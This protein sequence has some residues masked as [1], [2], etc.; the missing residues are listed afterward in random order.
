MLPRMPLSHDAIERLV[1]TRFNPTPAQ[2]SVGTRMLDQLVGQ[3]RKLASD[4]V[5]M[6][7]K[8]AKV[9][10]H[11]HDSGVFRARYATWGECVRAELDITPNYAANL[12]RV[13]REFREE[14]AVRL[15]LSKCVLLMKANEEDRPALAA[16]VESGEIRTD[17]KLR[18][19][20][21]RANRKLPRGSNGKNKGQHQTH[22]RVR[23]GASVVTRLKVVAADRGTEVEHLVAEAVREFLARLG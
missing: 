18:R 19:E 5:V 1:P 7:W 8:T 4:S 13:A 15:G 10:A 17:D 21:V 6:W 20:V 9:V 16:K 23:L 3:F 2:K 14:R 12:M 22:V 11:I